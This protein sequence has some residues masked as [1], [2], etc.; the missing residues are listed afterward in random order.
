MGVED[1]IR[2]AIEVGERNGAITFEQLNAICDPKKM[3]SED[4]ERVMNALS[5]A[6]IR[7]EEE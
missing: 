1:T 5:E 2:K 6:G 4:I 3:K 7:I